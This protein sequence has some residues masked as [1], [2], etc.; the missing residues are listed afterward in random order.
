MGAPHG[1][2][3]RHASRHGTPLDNPS[4]TPWSNI[5]TAEP[6]RS[7]TLDDCSQTMAPTDACSP[8][9]SNDAAASN[10]LATCQK[11]ST[12]RSVQDLPPT[13]ISNPSWK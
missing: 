7:K 1:R 8:R 5:L 11:W 10:Q 9:A 3:P 6:F 12:H 13:V 4:T 2:F